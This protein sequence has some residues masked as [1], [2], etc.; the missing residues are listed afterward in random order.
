MRVRNT[1]ITVHKIIIKYLFTSG[2]L[3]RRII[4]LTIIFAI[5]GLLSC[6]Q[7]NYC[8]ATDDY[9]QSRLY[10]STWIIF[11]HCTS[12]S[13]SSSSSSLF[14]IN[15]LQTCGIAQG[16]NKVMFV[17]LIATSH[18]HCGTW[19]NLLFNNYKLIISCFLFSNVV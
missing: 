9:A 4:L 2:I 8:T 15:H 1:D 3:L 18:I 11:A 19:H 17:R 7:E 13:S 12:S 10:R 16:H 5:Q 14:S 6:I